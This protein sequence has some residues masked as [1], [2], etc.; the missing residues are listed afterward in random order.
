MLTSLAKNNANTPT[1]V[2]IELW[3]SG[4]YAFADKPIFGIGYYHWQSFNQKLVD[5]NLVDPIV[6]QFGRSH[7]SF[8][9][10]L[11]I[12][13]IIGLTA[14]MT[15]FLLPMYFSL[16]GGNL[17]HDVFIELGVAH[18]TLVM[19]YC[20]TQNYINHHSSTLQYLM[21]VVIFYAMLYNENRTLSS[22]KIKDKQWKF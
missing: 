9:E 14:L 7:N 17:K 20:L 5:N 6:F 21:F 3:K 16:R 13:G 10:E 19:G 18:I 11:S 12:K 8:I 1:G 22:K 15:F 2:R 4:V